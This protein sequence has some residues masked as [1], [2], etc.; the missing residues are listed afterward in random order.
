M[1]SLSVNFLTDPS[2]ALPPVLRSPNA[3]AQAAAGGV[4]TAVQENFLRLGGRKFWQSAA[5][6]TRVEPTGRGKAEVSVYRR[7]VA[8]RLLGGKVYAKPGHAMALPVRRNNSTDLWP[9]EIPG[10]TLVRWR[11]DGRIRAG[12]S[13]D[14]RVLFTLV[15]ATVHPANPAVMPSP[16]SLQQAAASGIAQLIP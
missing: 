10:L 8:L 16:D 2:R 12:L 9:R 14:G 11:R 5:E 15:K 7:G 4:R 13:K 3:A 6:L 1:L